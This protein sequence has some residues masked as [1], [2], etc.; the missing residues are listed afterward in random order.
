[1]QMMRLAVVIEHY[2]MIALSIVIVVLAVW[3]LVDCLRHG[4]DR[5]VQEGKKTK[6]FW[7]AMTVASAAVALLGMVSGSSIGF[8]Q[9]IGASIACVYLADVKPAV[10]GKG[11][12]YNY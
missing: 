2:L 3:A 8:L 9:L 1:M 10:S 7:T 11:G 6:G 5:F 12:W 4:A